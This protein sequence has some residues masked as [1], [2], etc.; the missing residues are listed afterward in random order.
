M[1]R[2][3][4][5]ALLMQNM[6]KAVQRQRDQA[7]DALAQSLATIEVLQAQTRELI[8]AAQELEVWG[9][10]EKKIAGVVE[11]PEPP[12]GEDEG[13]AEGEAPE[14]DAA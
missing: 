4:A 11:T 10:I 9:D 8:A 12:K 7:Q 14:S 5:T 13:D 1:K 6:L 2:E 3:E